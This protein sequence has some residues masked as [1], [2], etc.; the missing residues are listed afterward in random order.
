MPLPP[1]EAGTGDA[2]GLCGGIGGWGDDLAVVGLSKK[3]KIKIT[4]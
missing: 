1:Y 3:I 4:N 2:P